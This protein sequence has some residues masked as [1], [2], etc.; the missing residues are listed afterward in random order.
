[1]KSVSDPTI[2]VLDSNDHKGCFLGLRWTHWPWA[3]SSP[4]EVLLITGD[5][6]CSFVYSVLS[7]S[8]KVWRKSSPGS[9][10]AIAPI[11]PAGAI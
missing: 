11:G 1:M 2:V 10:L 5:L 6:P 7:N 4:K 3:P 9:V 8:V